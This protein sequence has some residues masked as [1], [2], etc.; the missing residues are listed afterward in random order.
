V[1]ACK[2]VLANALD[3]IAVSAPER[4]VSADKKD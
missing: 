3:L 4:M 1:E 2:D